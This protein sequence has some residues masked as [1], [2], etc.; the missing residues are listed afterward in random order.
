MNMNTQYDGSKM[1]EPGLRKLVRPTEAMQRGPADRS[2][3]IPL[4]LNDIAQATLETCELVEKLEKQ[5]DAISSPEDSVPD[6][7]LNKEPL[8]LAPVLEMLRSTLQRVHATNKRL[9]GVMRRVEL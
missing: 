1:A 5:L 8:C 9:I 6:P 4:M 7:P 2:P 3:M